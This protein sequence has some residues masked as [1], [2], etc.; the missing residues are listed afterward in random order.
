MQDRED[1]YE[2]EEFQELLNEYESSLEKGLPL[3][4]DAEDL[5]EVADFY[6][7]LGRRDEAD[8]AI[9]KALEKDPSCPSAL[10][11]KVGDALEKGDLAMGH[12]YL[13][14]IEDHED[15]EYIYCNAELMLEEG[16]TKECDKMLQKE[17]K[18]QPED[19][20]D[21]FVLDV[22]NIYCDWEEWQ[23]AAKWIKLIKPTDS[24]DLRELRGRI[25]YGLGGY[26]E[27]EQIFKQLLDDNP[28]NLRHW[29]ALA[30]SQ[31]MLGRYQDALESSEYAIAVDAN[32]T[33]ALLGKANALYHLDRFEEARDFFH[34]YCQLTDNDPL[35]VMNEASCLVAMNQIDEAT[36][37]L[38]QLSVRQDI[39]DDLLSD[40]HQ[41]LAFCYGEQ[42]QYE[43]AIAILE[44]SEPSQPSDQQAT[45]LKGHLMLAAGKLDEAEA[46]FHK[47]IND[48]SEPMKTLLQVIVSLYDNGYLT[49]AHKMMGRFFNLQGENGHDGYGYMALFCHD[50]GYRKE[51]LKYLKLAVDHNLKETEQALKH[52]FPKGLEPS[53]YYTYETQQK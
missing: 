50:L 28:F 1:Y 46:T 38:E 7:S 51:Y 23:L 13:D 39:D 49:M 11:F 27:S 25:H 5:V 36:K 17:L 8:V 6:E 9:E 2:S 52:L 47:A 12:Y 30:S 53:L 35:G 45:V 26:E 31:F 21:N 14:Q 44:L 15:P 18:A 33:D 43:Q 19:E 22:L 37:M 4:M 42:K 20:V 40:I 16:R 29:N 41:Q 32:S 34:R 48:S 24:N 10:S 3:F